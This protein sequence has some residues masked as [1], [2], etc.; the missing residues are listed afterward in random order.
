M[1]WKWCLC[2]LFQILLCLFFFKSPWLVPWQLHVLWK[3]CIHRIS[4]MN[5]HASHIFWEGNQI[6]D[7]LACFGL[8]SSGMT[9]WDSP[10][11]FVNS[12]LHRDVMGLPNFRFR[13]SVVFSCIDDVFVCEVLVYVPLSF[14]FSFELAL[15]FRGS[16]KKKFNVATVG[17]LEEK[18]VHLTP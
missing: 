8:S 10:P 2:Q 18:V 17:D 1:I 9:C 15:F 11:E 14:F 7:A 4:L 3:N 16:I 6:V 12:N 5:F 13:W